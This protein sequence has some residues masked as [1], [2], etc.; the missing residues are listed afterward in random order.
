MLIHLKPLL[1]YVIR[2]TD[3][4]LGKVKDFYFDDQDWVIRYLV[5]DT[6]NWLPGRLV[7]IATDA[8]G[9]PEWNAEEFPVKLTAKKVENSPS[10]DLDQPV[11]RQKEQALRAYFQWPAYW[12]LSGAPLART[13]KPVLPDEAQQALDQSN[14]FGDP[15]L[16]NVNEV[17]DYSIQAV[18]GK[19]G[20]VDDFIIDDQSWHVKYMVVDT[21]N[22]LPGKKVLVAPGWIQDIS[23]TDKI[24]S[25]VHTR[26]QIQSCPEFDPDI[27]LTRDYEQ[28]IYQHYGYANY[29]V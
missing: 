5:V 4:N 14:D 1:S 29:W 11:S 23:W 10:I 25:V 21:G 8:M 22:W 6:G 16:Q 18:D 15:H 13:V 19:I 28:Q 20:H 7:L 3:Q 17:L 26:E 27:P 24:A 12:D 2:A 9:L